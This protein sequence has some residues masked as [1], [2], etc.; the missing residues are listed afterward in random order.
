MLTRR[1]A[2]RGTASAA[3][4]FAVWLVLVFLAGCTSDFLGDPKPPVSSDAALS[5]TSSSPTSTVPLP[6]NYGPAHDFFWGLSGDGYDPLKMYP[7]QEGDTTVILVAIRV[8]PDK[9]SR[10]FYDAI[11]DHA[12]TLA[13]Q[14]GIATGRAER[15]RVVLVEAT[16]EQK[17][18][19]STDSTLVAAGGGE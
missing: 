2:I 11:Y 1:G 18:I 7:V 5:D 16:T 12:T 8:A 13:K 17:V 10:A 3:A 14:Y 15:L 6:S 4:L 9:E 19:E